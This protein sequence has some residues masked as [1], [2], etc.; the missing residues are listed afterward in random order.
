MNH[1]AKQL[2]SNEHVYSRLKEG[3]KANSHSL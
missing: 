1:I 3:N 2:G